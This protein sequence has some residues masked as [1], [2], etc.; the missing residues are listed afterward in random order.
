MSQFD[1]RRGALENKFAHDQEHMFRL[2]ARAVKLFG[3][4][5]AELM[6]LDTEQAKAYAKDLVAFN[7]DVPGLQ[8]VTGK[9]SKDLSAKGVNVDHHQIDAKMT[10]CLDLADTQLEAEGK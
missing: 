7:L 8:D 1:E 4:W 10:E 5:A 3:L 2:E 9:A 6:Q